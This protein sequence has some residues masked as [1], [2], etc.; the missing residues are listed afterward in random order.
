MKILLVDVDSKIP[1]L[2]LMK[3]STYHKS[4]GDSIEL[5]KL[6]LPGYPHNRKFK[7]VDAKGFDKVYV[8]TIFT[9]NQSKY[10]ILNNDNVEYGG[11]GYDLT[12]KL[13]Q[14]IDDLPEDYSIYPDN[15]ISY[16]YITRGCIRNCSFCFVP[17]KEGKLSYY[18]DWQK[19]LQEGHKQIKFLDNN[20]LAYE[21]HKEILQELIDA[22]VK[23]EFNQG[24]DI[25]LI[26]EENSELLKKL[27]YGDKYTFAFDNIKDEKIIVEKLRNYLSWGQNWRLRLFIYC[28]ADMSLSDVIYRIMFCKK[29]KI[30]PYL[31]RDKNCWLDLNQKDFSTD[32]AGFVNQ[33][34]IIK[35]LDFEEYLV[36]R[37]N[38]NNKELQKFYIDIRTYC[39]WHDMIEPLKVKKDFYGD[40]FKEWLDY[41][42][43]EKHLTKN[44]YNRILTSLKPWED[45]YAEP[46]YLVWGKA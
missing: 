19:I 21:N 11:T 40:T 30:M 6:N 29:N 20:F 44:S 16:G 10:E 34:N 37:H 9:V 4:L 35:K 22:K 13:S 2:A 7:S 14:E 36:K 25:R 43:K 12:V 31:M 41:H 39:N 46:N 33:P 3:L 15:N 32:L 28:N 45:N 23:V 17:K 42:Y 1:N 38:Q 5:L 18:N 24:L 8:S 26:D 27:K